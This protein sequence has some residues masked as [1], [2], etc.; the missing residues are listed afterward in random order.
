MHD[1]KH[2]AAAQAVSIIDRVLP[3]RADRITD[4]VPRSAVRAF[5]QAVLVE[6]CGVRCA[7]EFLNRCT[8]FELV[9]LIERHQIIGEVGNSCVPALFSEAREA[10]ARCLES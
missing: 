3:P 6:A 9:L 7:V 8:L 4:K 10:L 2:V 5:C 1:E